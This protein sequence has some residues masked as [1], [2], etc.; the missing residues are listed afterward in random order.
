MQGK[1]DLKLCHAHIVRNLR[2]HL[3]QHPRLKG[4]MV[5]FFSRLVRAET[6]EEF[7][8]LL[9]AFLTLCQVECEC[10]CY[11]A[12][13]RALDVGE[14]ATDDEEDEADLDKPVF[15]R[16]EEEI[17]GSQNG[18]HADALAIHNELEVT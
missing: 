18:F 9:R 10:A 16:E 6:Y 11:E 7:L 12:A 15:E 4:L 1:V 14:I 8:F 5:R 2:P 3:P 13:R 17:V